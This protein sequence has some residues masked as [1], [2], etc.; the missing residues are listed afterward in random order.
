MIKRTLFGIVAATLILTGCGGGGG[1]SAPT[2]NG[3]TGAVS[4]SST[5]EGQTAAGF[6]SNEA[7]DSGLSSVTNIAA[8]PFVA[9]NTATNFH[10]LSTLAQ[11]YAEIAFKADKSGPN[12]PVGVTGSQTVNCPSGGSATVTVVAASQTTYT[13]GDTVTFAYNNCVTSLYRISGTIK[14][15][16]GSFT[17]GSAFSATYTF[18]RLTEVQLST[19]NSGVIHG[20]F[21]ASISNGAQ[22]VSNLSGT[23]LLLQNTTAGVTNQILISNFSY[24]DTLNNTTGNVTVDHDFTYASTLLGGS[25]TVNTV[26]PFIIYSG[27]IYPTTGQ[28]VV[29]GASNAKV[30]LSAV[31]K[32]SATLEYDL[33]GTGYTAP[34]TI[35]WVDL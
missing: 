11:K 8:P 34:V 22:L 17:S 31:N 2:Y 28:L 33:D 14:L 21:T 19:G 29:T 10:A 26:T 1:S 3:P 24:V 30:R 18:D 23:S 32:T 35:L 13:A 5:T 4:L 16:I 12:L 7:F 20:S 9:S 6:A 15:T 27:D 25:I